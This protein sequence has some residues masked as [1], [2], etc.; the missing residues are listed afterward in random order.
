M[1]NG[2]V[3]R[4]R[5][6]DMVCTAEAERRSATVAG[7]RAVARAGRARRIVAITIALLPVPLKH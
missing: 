4:Y 3:A 1:L 2:D 7:E 6:N 5:V